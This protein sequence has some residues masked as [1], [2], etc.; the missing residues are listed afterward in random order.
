MAEL[1]EDQEGNSKHSSSL[2]SRAKKNIGG[3]LASSKL[4]RKALKESLPQEV[5]NLIQVG[6]F[7]CF[8][9]TKIVSFSLVGCKSL[10]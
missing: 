1:P 3:K 5:T 4:G 9:F 7:F 8:T 10:C 6:F 2:A